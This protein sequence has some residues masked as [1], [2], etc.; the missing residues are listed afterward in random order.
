MDIELFDF[1]N[2]KKILNFKKEEEK[3]LNPWGMDIE[4]FIVCIMK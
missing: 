2:F 4:S 1:F 3:L